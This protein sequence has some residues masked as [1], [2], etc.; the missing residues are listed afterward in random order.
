MPRKRNRS[1]Y[2]LAEYQ[3]EVDAAITPAERRAALQRLNAIKRHRT[4]PR[5]PEAVRR[6]GQKCRAAKPEQYRAYRE[7]WVKTLSGRK[8][9]REA[10][11]KH[12]Y[13]LTLDDFDNLLRSQDYRCALCRIPDVAI[14]RRGGCKATKAVPF[15]VDHDHITGKVRGLLCQPCNSGIGVLGDNQSGLERALAYLKVSSGR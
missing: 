12:L 14:E 4:R 7:H 10:G 11:L 8:S 3:A 5:D 9:R 1:N 6:C 13:N 2:S 15:D